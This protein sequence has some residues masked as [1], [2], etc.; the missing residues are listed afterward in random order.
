MEDTEGVEPSPA[1]FA[2]ERRHPAQRV[3]DGGSG[4]IRTRKPCSDPVSN[5]TP[6]TYEDSTSMVG[7]PGIEP[8]TRCVYS[9]AVLLGACVP[10]CSERDS[11]PQPTV[12]DT[13]ALPLSYPSMCGSGEDRTLKP[14][15]RPFSRR[16]QSPAFCLH[17]HVGTGGG[18]RTPGASVK[19]RALWP[20]SYTCLLVERPGIE[21]G[22]PDL[23][24]RVPEPLASRRIVLDGAPG[25]SRTPAT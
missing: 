17:F 9:A 1:R 20:L 3:R 15:G 10:W 21:P 23:S 19:S 18:S 24:D 22:Q 11:N 4:R 2:G 13:A 8:G 7:H 16:V 6:L 14:F 12:C 5:R 25:G